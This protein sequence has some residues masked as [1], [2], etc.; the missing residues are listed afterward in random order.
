ME[1]ADVRALPA[2]IE[3]LLD[4][5]DEPRA[6]E[7][8]EDLVAAVLSLYGEGL[9]R[10]VA[11]AGPDVLRALL[12]DDLVAGLL[13]LHGLHPDD[14]G[15]RVQR[16]LDAV[17]PYLGSHAGGIDLLG[18][19]G[20]G[21]AHLR[22]QGS[23]DHCPS[24]S[25]TVRLAVEQAVLEAAPE[26]VRVEVEGMVAAPETQ[27]LLQIGTR[28]PDPEADGWR[29]VE[30]DAVPGQLQRLADLG[31]VAVNVGGT[32][33]VY[34]DRCPACGEEMSRGRLDAEVLRCAGCGQRFDARR[35][36]RALD[37]GEPLTPVPLL[38]DGAG[39][40]VALAKAAVS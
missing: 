25:E 7:R 39:W 37:G 19:D 8:A 22:L 15:T 24:S 34:R 9:R 33:C 16:A 26:V 3:E 30:L 35:A 32:F 6:A 20:D 10:V 4:G 5:F 1:A 14:V 23:C 38:P 36:G 17:R 12:D 21:V 29:P 13:L 40:R 18:V 31:V 2:R 11:L 27:P 28:P